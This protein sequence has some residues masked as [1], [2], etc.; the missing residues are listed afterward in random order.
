MTVQNNTK[1]P[2]LQEYMKMKEAGK[3]SFRLSKPLDDELRS[4]MEA[5]GWLNKTGFFI[6]NSL[7]DDEEIARLL[8]KAISSRDKEEYK[9]ILT[10]YLKDLDNAFKY[11]E[12][13]F[14]KDM[15]ILYKTEGIRMEEWCAKTNRWT[16][17][18][19]REIQK[20]QDLFLK[21]KNTALKK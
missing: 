20:K 14:E 13:M 12:K 6:Y 17:K 1:K 11:F 2:G 7:G 21:M 4:K 18:F 16:A 10:T 15:D 19:A 3:I 5:D 9:L 8:N